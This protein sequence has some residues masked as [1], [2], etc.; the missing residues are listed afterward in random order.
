MYKRVA[1]EAPLDFH[2]VFPSP[3]T[4]EESVMIEAGVDLIHKM[5]C[6]DPAK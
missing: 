5:L 4:N 1:P 3:E 6:F 2:T